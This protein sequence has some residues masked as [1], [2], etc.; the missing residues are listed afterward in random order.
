MP[1][2]NAFFTRNQVNAVDGAG[3]DAQVAPG[4]FVRNHRMHHLGGT[5]NRIYWAGLNAFCTANAFILA[6]PGHHRL[7][8]HA[9][10]SVQRLRFDVQ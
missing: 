2:T 5:E 4:A 1:E 3:L 6:D 8:L 9:V 10:L 7:S